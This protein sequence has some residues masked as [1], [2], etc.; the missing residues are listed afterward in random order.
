[1]PVTLHL[2]DQAVWATDP[3]IKHDLQRIYADAPAERLGVPV[4][5]FLREHLEAGHFFACARFNERLLGAVAVS[6]DDQAW[7]LSELCVRKATRRRGV[8]SRLLAL[9]SDAARTAGRELRTHSW[10]LPV[11][12]QVLLT[13]LGYRL[14]ITGDHFVLAPPLQGGGNP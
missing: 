9:V 3:Q 13:R 12:D 11:A 6:A 10:Q 2:V 8:G 4:A 7:W 5:A 14:D 1:M